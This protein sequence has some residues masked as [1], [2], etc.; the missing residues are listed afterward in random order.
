MEC[1][2]KCKGCRY[3]NYC[4]IRMHEWLKNIEVI[5]SKRRTPDGG[6]LMADQAISY[7]RKDFMGGIE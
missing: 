7:M 1:P 3:L 5:L 4:K 2:K 6:Q